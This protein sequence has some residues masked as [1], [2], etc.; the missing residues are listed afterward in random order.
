VVASDQRRSDRH[1]EGEFAEFLAAAEGVE[2]KL[3]AL[4]VGLGVVQL[5]VDLGLVVRV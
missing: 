3:R 2:K 5:L 1:R 4:L